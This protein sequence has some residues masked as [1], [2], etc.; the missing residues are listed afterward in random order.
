MQH[1]TNRELPERISW[2]R[3]MIFAVGFFLIAAILVGQLPSY[4]Y[5]V[6]TA[7]TLEGAEQGILALAVVCLAGFV[8]IQVIVL[9]FDPKPVV[10]PGLLIGIGAIL[11]LAGLVLFLWASLTGCTPAVQTCNQFF[12]QATTSWNPILGGNFLWLRAG[13]IDFVMLSF[14]LIGV[15]A[16]MVF[17]SVLAI[18]EQRNPD[19]RDLGTTP[20][21]R[22]M[23]IGGIMLLI[24]ALLLYTLFDNQAF[25]AQLFPAHPFVGFR[26][27]NLIDGLILG[28]AI[29]LSIA[30][31]ALRLH[32]LMRPVRKRTMP[33]LYAIGSLGLA[34]TGAIL[35]VFWLVMYP[36]VAWIH[37]WTFIGLGT[38]LVNCSQKTNVPGSCTF[39]QDS[40]Y[41]ID[42]IVSS[43]FFVL[44]LAA[45][46][47]WKSNRNLVVVGG[48]VITAVIAAA[49]F[50]VHTAPNEIIVAMMLC[51]GMLVV[52]VI[53]TSVARREFAVVGENNL[54]C[55]G[56]WLVMGTCLFIYLASFAFFSLPVWPPET[57]PNVTF[58][59]GLIVPPPTPAGQTPIVPAL[60]AIVM[61]VLMGV[62]AGIQFYFLTRNR[63][64]V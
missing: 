25:G 7:S 33:G 37:G 56:M 39:S 18:R 16:A 32:Y 59:P 10:P 1:A 2:A 44:L 64:K 21:I 60:D 11:T 5:N 19:R 40:G 36:L 17:Y 49:T 26:L 3:A 31:L 6:A 14:G 41:I 28:A 35:L 13:A 15:G 50:M 46:W 45:I 23:L 61:L 12:P 55:L 9:L 24:L 29:F 47:A 53:W 22:Y 20:S 48:I 8:I 52:G 57:E 38:F 34:Q 4:I 63:Y 43:N 54:G 51:V 58:Q 27:L 30:A 62:L 42:T